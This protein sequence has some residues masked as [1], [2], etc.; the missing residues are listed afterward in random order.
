MKR[1]LTT[2]ALLAAFV[3]VLGGAWLL[4]QN[5]GGNAGPGLAVADSSAA[6]TTDGSA[7]GTPQSSAAPDGEAAA[8]TGESGAGEPRTEAPDFTVYD[9]GEAVRPGGQ[10]GDFELL[11]QLVRPLQERDAR[12]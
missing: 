9:A 2:L 10:A 8:A 1:K 11:G 6:A 7:G 12:L 3:L 4:Y 5:L